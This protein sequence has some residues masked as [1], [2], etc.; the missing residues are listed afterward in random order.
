VH[1]TLIAPLLKVVWTKF[2]GDML[3]ICVL[4]YELL[5]AAKATNPQLTWNDFAALCQKVAARLCVS[6]VFTSAEAVEQFIHLRTKYIDGLNMSVAEAI[7]NVATEHSAN[8]LG[9]VAKRL[10]KRLRSVSG[11]VV[12]CC[13]DVCAAE[14]QHSDFASWSQ[15]W[16][17]AFAQA[18]QLM[19]HNVRRR[20]EQDFRRQCFC[21]IPCFF[22]G[23]RR[24]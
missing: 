5:V 10:A 16:C 18:A 17:R 23:R 20:T 15:F 13:A 22:K 4:I 14:C 11:F 19:E 24:H 8:V 9:D 12:L 3:D 21:G 6:D 2:P 1:E 7:H